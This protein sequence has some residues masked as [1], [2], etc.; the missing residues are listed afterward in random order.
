M[1]NYQVLWNG[2]GTGCLICPPPSGFIDLLFNGMVISRTAFSATGTTPT[3]TT[4]SVLF[5]PNIQGTHGFSLRVTSTS[6][7]DILIV[8]GG[9]GSANFAA[10]NMSLIV[11]QE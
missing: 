8:G 6:A 2:K 1:I 5:T 11:I 3:S 9:Q 7:H 10:T 4:G